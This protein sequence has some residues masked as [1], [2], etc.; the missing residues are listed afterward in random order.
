VEAWSQFAGSE[1]PMFAAVVPNI[2]L[3]SVR[4]AL[5]VRST[6]AKQGAQAPPPL[7]FA[8]SYLTN[9]CNELPIQG[10]TAAHCVL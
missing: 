4:D 2:T 1:P 10:M 8:S 6:F 7:A 5:K 3:R 9:V